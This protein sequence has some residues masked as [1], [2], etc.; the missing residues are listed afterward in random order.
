[1][2]GTRPRPAAPAKLSLVIP[3]DQLTWI[4]PSLPSTAKLARQ[5]GVQP[6][7]QLGGDNVERRSREVHRLVGQELL[8][9][10][11]HERV[12]PA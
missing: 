11:Y 2:I 6:A 1:M 8:A 5:C 12:G 4:G 3:A 9:V 7:E 10:L